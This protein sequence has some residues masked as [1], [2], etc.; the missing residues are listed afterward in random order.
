MKDLEEIQTSTDNALGPSGPAS[1]WICGVDRT[2]FSL[3]VAL[4]GCL[5][6]TPASVVRRVLILCYFLP[7]PLG[8]G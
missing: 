8:A 4:L 3:P 1:G 5:F 2:A 7:V 6:S